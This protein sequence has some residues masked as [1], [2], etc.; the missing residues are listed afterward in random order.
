VSPLPDENA[1]LIAMGPCWSC[2]ETFGFSPATVISIPIDP[3]T[4]LPPDIGHTDPQRAVSQP[5][6]PRCVVLID[7]RRAAQ[8]L[9]PVRKV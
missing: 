2:K 8:G 6:C 4:A 9:A 5:I 7:Q 1:D 3:G